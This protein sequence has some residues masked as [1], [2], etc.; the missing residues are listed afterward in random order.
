MLEGIHHIV[1]FCKNTE[2]SKEW[3]EKVGF[4]Y[5]NGYE[6]MHWFK[7]GST[8]IMLHPAE[9]TNPGYTAIHVGVHDVQEM[10]QHVVNQGLEPIDHQQHGEKI[11]APVERPWG[12]VEFELVDP[13]GHQWAFTQIK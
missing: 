10:F 9:T 3:Y 12:D 5:M 8:Q 13:E 1:L 11:S 4:T 6:D 2:S 7:I